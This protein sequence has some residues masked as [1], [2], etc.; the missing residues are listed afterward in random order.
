MEYIVKKREF[1]KEDIEFIEMFFEN[2]DCIPFS[3]AEIVDISV[4]LYDNL[5][6]G[7]DY[8]NSLCAVVE[9]GFVKLKLL[10]KPKRLYA[11]AF[12]FDQREF[13]KDRIGF[14]EKRLLNDGGVNCIKLFNDKNWYF[15]L[16]CAVE[17]SSEDDCLI[18][19]FIAR[20][21]NAEY[22]SDTHHVLLPEINKSI[23]RRL[24][25]DFEN[26]EGVYI[27]SKEIVE[28]KLN[29]SKQL[30]WCAGDYVR[31]I[32][33]GYIKIK[34]DPNANEWRE[35]A[36]FDNLAKGKKGNRQIERRICG[37]KGFELHDICHLYIEFEYAGS[38]SYRR[39]CIEIDDVRSE[40]ELAKIEKIEEKEEQ[41][42][43]PPYI[44]GYAEKI[45]DEVLITF[46]K[47]ALREKRCLDELKKC[48]AYDIKD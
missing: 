4:R 1:K 9:S 8:W 26:C 39:E 2:G 40:E 48:L 21:K 45:G 37:K 11:S 35:N 25:L 14:I 47:T 24:T 6:V 17:T 44:G 22:M 18:L 33:S 13:N 42:F 41:N 12:V 30:R 46:G 5:I 20:N 3:K 32:E 38:G 36:L 10:K 28:M 16:Y 15:S 7:N 29:L 23:I 43:D 31:Q 27:D 19:K 34:L